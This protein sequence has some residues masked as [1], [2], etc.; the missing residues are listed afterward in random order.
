MSPPQKTRNFGPK[1]GWTKETWKKRSPANLTVSK[2]D[3]RRR[4]RVIVWNG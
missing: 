3:E 4:S 2:D 1:R